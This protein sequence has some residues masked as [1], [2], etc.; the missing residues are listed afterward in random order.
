MAGMN[1]QHEFTKPYRNL[2]VDGGLKF[3][4]RNP[5]I[6]ATLLADNLYPLLCANDWFTKE[7][8]LKFCACLLQNLT[9]GTIETQVDG[10][11]LDRIR[12][13]PLSQGIKLF[14]EADRQSGLYVLV[15][16]ICQELRGPQQ[17]DPQQQRDFYNALFEK[18][19]PKNAAVQR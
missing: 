11:L 2:T 17:L 16:L 7:W 8:Q 3:A 12:R 19:F 14:E 6:C 5:S 9:D 1:M 10:Q 4:A 15:A 18:F 13:I